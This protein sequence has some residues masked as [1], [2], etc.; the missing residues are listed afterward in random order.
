[1]PWWRR[2]RLVLLAVIAVLLVALAIGLGVGLTHRSSSNNSDSAES[3]GNRTE[4]PLGFPIGQWTVP[5]TLLEASTECTSNAATWRCYPYTVGGD[6]SFDLTITNTSAQYA[7]N[8]TT[9]ENTGQAGQPAGLQIS[10]SNPFVIPFANQTVTYF[11]SAANA[12]AA[13]LEWSFSMA[14]TVVPSSP[15]IE[16]GAAAECLFPDTMLTG[17]LYLNAPKMMAGAT[18]SAW[19]YA[20]EIRQAWQ[21]GNREIECQGAN[22]GSAAV[23]AAEGDCNCVYRNY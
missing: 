11:S 4:Q 6:T 10:S 23:A 2:K 7:P 21:G 18:E 1:M 14:K 19:P 22:G 3:P 16:G 17:I 15:V 13:R 9:S 5:A 12:S 20:A 8:S